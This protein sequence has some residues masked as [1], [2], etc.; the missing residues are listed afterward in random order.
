ME[1]GAEKRK[2][3]QLAIGIVSMLTSSEHASTALVILS[4]VLYFIYITLL[5]TGVPKVALL[6]F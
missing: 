1:N 3:L 6:D 2:Q 4:M 5:Y